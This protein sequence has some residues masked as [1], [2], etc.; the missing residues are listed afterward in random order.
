MCLI[1]DVLLETVYLQPA[2]RC[3]DFIGIFIDKTWMVSYKLKFL[4][5]VNQRQ[6]QKLQYVR[7][8]MDVL[9]S[10]IVKRTKFQFALTVLEP[11]CGA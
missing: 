7:N 3:S 11:L 6:K 1:E 10:T 8:T 4:V 2:I 9:L 5:T